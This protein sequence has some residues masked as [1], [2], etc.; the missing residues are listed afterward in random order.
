MKALFTTPKKRWLP[1]AWLIRQWLSLKYGR[2]VTWSHSAI[3]M[4]IEGE[5]IVFQ[6]NKDGAHPLLLSDFLEDHDILASIDINECYKKRCFRYSMEKVLNEYSYLSILAIM[7]NLPFSD[8]SRKVI[9]SEFTA[10]SLNLKVDRI[11]LIDPYKLYEI[12]KT[13]VRS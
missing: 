8:G 9:C 12:L 7:L 13:G 11:D 6:A 2:E 3:L 5:E 4:T 10:R 1:F